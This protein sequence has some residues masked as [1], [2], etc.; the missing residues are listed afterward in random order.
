M[1]S[2][3]CAICRKYEANIRSLK[4]F[5]RDWIT[6]STNQRISN[7]IDHATNDVHKAAMV[8]L[9][10]E[11]SRAR[12]ESAA[13]STTIERLLSLPISTNRVEQ[14]FSSLKVIK[15][16]HQTSINNSTLHDLLEI[17]VEGHPLSSFN[18]DAAIQL[19]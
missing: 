1:W 15:T 13:T 6:G 14:L 10:V 2:L 7:L 11:H 16:K 5:R 4:N 9:K 3:Y 17:N 12:G 8:K 18:A 19:W